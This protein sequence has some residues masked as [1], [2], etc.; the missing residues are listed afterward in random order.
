MQRGCDSEKC[1]PFGGRPGGRTVD[2]VSA[3]LRWIVWRRIDNE[4]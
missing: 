2:H 1:E 3:F 4:S